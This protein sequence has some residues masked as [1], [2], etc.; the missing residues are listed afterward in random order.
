MRCVLLFIDFREEAQGDRD[1]RGMELRQMHLPAQV[2]RPDMR[3]V[4]HK[5][6]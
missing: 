1:H 4:Q 5:S 2:P 6:Q 3:Y